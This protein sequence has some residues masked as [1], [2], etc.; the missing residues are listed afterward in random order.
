[1][2]TF[3][4]IG[5]FDSGVGGLSVVLEIFKQLPK[6]SVIYFADIAHQPYGTKTKEEIENIVLE[7]CR[8]LEKQKVKLIIIACNTADAFGLT[9]AQKTFNIPIIGV[10][11]PGSQAAARAT[12]NKKIGI[13]GS[14]GLINSKIYE[15]YLK[16]INSNIQVFGQP[17]DT[18]L[19]PFA[20]EEGKIH[21]NSTKRLVKEHLYSLKKEDVDTIILGSTHYPF[22]KGVIRDII[23]AKII[24]IDPAEE[25]VQQTKKILFAKNLLYNDRK[26]VIYRFFTSGNPAKFKTTAEQLIKRKISFVNKFNLEKESL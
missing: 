21:T 13:L 26:K 22:L 18:S 4:S 10:I 9:L 15:K 17:S 24:L 23:E 2:D 11:K 5:L 7:I 16:S 14:K 25:T 19:V 8:F 20:V 6:E 12:Q 3:K 1:M